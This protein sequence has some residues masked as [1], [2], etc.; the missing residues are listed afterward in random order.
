MRFPAPP[1][2]AGRAGRAE[3]RCTASGLSVPDPDKNDREEEIITMHHQK[4]SGAGRVIVL[5][6]LVA[7][8]GVAQ[9]LAQ[10]AGSYPADFTAA[11]FK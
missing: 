4:S 3:T 1:S 8:T 2:V 7:L 5:S 6:A 10:N 9:A 11:P